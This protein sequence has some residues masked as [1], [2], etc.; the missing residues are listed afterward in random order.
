M[1]LIQ[2]TFLSVSTLSNCSFS[3]SSRILRFIVDKHSDTSCHCSEALRSCF[4]LI[5]L[6]SKHN[7]YDVEKWELPKWFFSFVGKETST[8]YY[9][10]LS[11]TVYQLV[12]PCDTWKL[13]QLFE[14]C[15]LQSLA[16]FG[17]PCVFRKQAKMKQKSGLKF[18]T[19]LF[20]RFCGFEWSYFFALHRYE[21][22]T[23]N[24]FF[25]V[26]LWVHFKRYTFRF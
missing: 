25:F 2:K 17:N 21:L 14:P 6:V 9:V 13:Y 16:E 20:V 4:P 18:I 1:K 3:S 8:R 10:K 15:Q 24:M 11:T 22:L 23:P 7:L 26:P 19:F 12:L 5:L